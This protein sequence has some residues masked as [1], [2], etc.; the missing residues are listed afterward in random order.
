MKIKYET[1]RLII[2]EWEE[3][4]YLD[5][6]EYASDPEVT[7][8]L[9][10]PPHAT[11]EVSMERIKLVRQKYGEHP[12]LGD[13]CIELKGE[14]KVIGSIAINGYKEKNEGEIEI[15]YSLS[16]AFQGQGYMTE[17][18]KGMFKYIKQNNYAKRIA[19]HHDATNIKS[20]NVMK[21]AGMTFEGI[22][23]KAGS[24][25]FHS[26]H[27]IAIYSILDEEIDV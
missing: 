21:R 17:A 14:N 12:I 9:H 10:F 20:G 3:K 25:N 27:D 6:F 7:K 19:L 26:R 1:E 15:G 8:F 5:M 13:F 18:L 4:D 22:M 23:R 2:R 16:R 24:N 11:P